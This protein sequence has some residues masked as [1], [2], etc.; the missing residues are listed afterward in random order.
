MSGS[1]PRYDRTRPRSAGCIPD[2]EDL[3]VR[4]QGDGGLVRALREPDDRC[5]KMDRAVSRARW[6]RDKDAR[7]GGFP[8]HLTL[9]SLL[10]LRGWSRAPI[11]FRRA[12]GVEAGSPGADF[13]PNRKRMMTRS[14]KLLRLAVSGAAAITCLFINDNLS[15]IERFSPI[16]QADARV[17]NPL[18]PGSVAG[19]TRRTTRRAAVMNRAAVGVGVFYCATDVH[20]IPGGYYAPGPCYY[21]ALAPALY[22]LPGYLPG[23]YPGSGEPR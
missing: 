16:T 1:S 14:L 2:I 8:P 13:P 9:K 19:A 21:G 12:K 23:P 17:R 11:S 10:R 18:T 22:A 15:S 7:C 20:Y 5:S 6:S 4:L 3:D